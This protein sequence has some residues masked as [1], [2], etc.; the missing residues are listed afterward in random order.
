[1]QLVYTFKL[2]EQTLIRQ[3]GEEQTVIKNL[4]ITTS[5]LV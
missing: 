3:K 4:P 2:Y 1:M 5:W